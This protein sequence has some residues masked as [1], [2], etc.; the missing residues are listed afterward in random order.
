LQEEVK[1][2][3]DKLKQIE[4]QKD[5]LIKQLQDDNKKLKDQ[6]A[7]SP[8]TP[9]DGDELMQTLNQLKQVSSEINC[10]LR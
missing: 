3:K 10:N 6:L 7:A 5:K 4:D 1:N 2:G 8:T 9:R